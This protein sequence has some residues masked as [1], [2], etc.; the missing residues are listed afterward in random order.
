MPSY[1]FPGVADIIRL[2]PRVPQ[3]VDVPRQRGIRRHRND[4]TAQGEAV[5]EN[6][7]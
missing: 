3:L 5:E 4:L 6:A 1:H 2:L 7:H